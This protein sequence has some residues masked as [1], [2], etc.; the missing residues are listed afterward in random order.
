MCSPKTELGGK[1][2]ERSGGTSVV[3]DPLIEDDA[4]EMLEGLDDGDVQ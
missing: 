3:L 2:K 1:V 4:L